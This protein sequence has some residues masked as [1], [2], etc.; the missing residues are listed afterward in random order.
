MSKSAIIIAV[1]VAVGSYTLVTM[2]KSDLQRNPPPK[3]QRSMVSLQSLRSLMPILRATEKKSI[4][5]YQAL[6]KEDFSIIA[7]EK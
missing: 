5:D 3:S 1:L 7:A 6:I 4:Y 2:I